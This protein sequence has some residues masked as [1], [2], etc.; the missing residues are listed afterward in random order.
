LAHLELGQEI[1]IKPRANMPICTGESFE[2]KLDGNHENL[3][4]KIRWFSSLLFF[5]LFF[6]LFLGF[7]TR[8]LID[9]VPTKNGPKEFFSTFFHHLS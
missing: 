4:R 9:D 2:Q 1:S 6:L 8:Q 5:F 7:F 3:I